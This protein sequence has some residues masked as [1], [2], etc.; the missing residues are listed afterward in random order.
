MFIINNVTTTTNN[1]NN[2][3]N[4]DDTNGNYH[5]YYYYYIYICICMYVYI[6]IYMYVYMYIYIHIH[7]Y[8]HTYILTY[9]HTYTYICIYVCIYIYMCVYEWVSARNYCNND[10]CKVGRV[11]RGKTRKVA[12]H[13]DKSSSQPSLNDKSQW[14]RRYRTG[15]ERE[16]EG[17]V[18]LLG[19]CER[20]LEGRNLSAPNKMRA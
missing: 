2:H 5:Y 11:G 19:R 20:R 4:N 17:S 3:N 7:T 9:I 14:Y 10:I 12:S 13:L 8:I 1:N 6:Y 18:V 16:R 15:V